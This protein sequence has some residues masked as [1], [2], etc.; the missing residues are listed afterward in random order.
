[1]TI[2]AY[3]PGEEVAIADGTLPAI[4]TCVAFYSHGG[5]L[6]E[7]AW[8]KDGNLHTAWI[9]ENQMSPFKFKVSFSFKPIQK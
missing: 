1:M 6:Y 8:W 3:A 7:V 4:I 9:A 5:I 2:E